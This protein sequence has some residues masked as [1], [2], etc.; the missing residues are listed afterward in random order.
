MFTDV[1][2]VQMKHV[3]CLVNAPKLIC[4]KVEIKKFSRG[5]TRTPFAGG[6]ATPF[7]G[8]HP[9]HGQARSL[10]DR[11]SGGGGRKPWGGGPPKI[12]W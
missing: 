11:L 9:Q 12:L 6:R 2:I 7:R 1:E 8:P 10:R 4:S 3:L 5:N